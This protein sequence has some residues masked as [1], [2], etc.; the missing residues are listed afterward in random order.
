MNNKHT[1]RVIPHAQLWKVYLEKYVNDNISDPMEVWA[2]RD[3]GVHF[4]HVFTISDGLQTLVSEDVAS[5][6]Q[7]ISVCVDTSVL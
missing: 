5:M 6:Q 2:L 7:H 3:F 4:E 1:L